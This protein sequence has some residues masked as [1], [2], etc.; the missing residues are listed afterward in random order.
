MAIDWLHVRPGGEW[1][2][3][4]RGQNKKSDFRLA[5]SERAVPVLSMTDKTKPYTEEGIFKAQSCL[6]ARFLLTDQVTT[7]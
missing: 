5:G 3:L 7:L 6:P 1:K 4:E 2:C